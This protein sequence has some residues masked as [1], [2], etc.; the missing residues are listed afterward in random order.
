MHNRRNYLS[1]SQCN[2]GHC[3]IRLFPFACL[4]LELQQICREELS[5]RV[6]SENSP[7]L[8]SV[9]MFDDYHNFQYCRHPRLSRPG[10]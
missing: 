4:L 2:Q 3:N 7:T 1:T 5:L 8:H 6:E 10:A 9:D